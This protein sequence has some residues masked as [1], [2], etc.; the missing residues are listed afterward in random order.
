MKRIVISGIGVISS[1][2]I[3]K[4]A[5]WDALIKGTS[6]IST[7]SSFDTSVF[8]THKG[9]EIKDFKPEQYIDPARVIQAG[10]ASQLAM[11]ASQLAYTDSRLS[12][13][14]CAPERFGLCFGTTMTETRILEELN[15]AWV[16]TGAMSIDPVLVPRYPAYV[17]ASNIAR[18]VGLQG[19][20]YTIPTACAA[21][22][23][24]IGY[25]YDLIRNDE[26]DMMLAGGADA[27]SRLAF[28][29]F[30]RLLA[31]A[32]DRVQPFDKNRKGMMVAEGAGVVILESLESALARHAPIYAEILGYGLSCDA[33]H[34]TAPEHNGIARAIENA[35]RE[36]NICPDEVDYFNAHGT[37]TPANDREESFAIKK[38]FGEYTRKLAVSSTKSMLGHTMGAASAIETIVCCMS[39]THDVIPPTI[40]YETP[41]PDCDIDCVPNICR[42]QKVTIALNS[43]SAFGGNNACLVLRKY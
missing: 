32:P 16:K 8:S 17:L 43:S 27:F 19:P 33:H 36:S 6:G 10:R 37:G 20:S 21:G 38:V 29:G 35:L 9:G 34:M 23:Y 15:A 13:G 7:I 25:A 3:G 22:N 28:I 14:A 18:M 41:D 2:G 12:S 31:V 40:N 11:A 24:A 39:L 4:D 42:K 5:F 26:A 30:N 1:I